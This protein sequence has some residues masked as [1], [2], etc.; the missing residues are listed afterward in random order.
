MEG[1]MHR[2]C[3]KVMIKHW[4]VIKLF[5]CGCL[6]LKYIQICQFLMIKL[7]RIFRGMALHKMIRLV[8]FSLGG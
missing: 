1:K 2:V 6:M 5:L 3:Q 7:L 4:L 8:T